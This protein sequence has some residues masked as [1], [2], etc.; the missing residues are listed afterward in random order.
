MDV[1]ST[2]LI[3]TLLIGTV[4]LIDVITR[5]DDSLAEVWCGEHLLTA[6]LIAQHQMK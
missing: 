5:E 3:A 4:R 1:L 2:L 6:I